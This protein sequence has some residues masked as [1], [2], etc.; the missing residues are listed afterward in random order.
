MTYITN[1]TPSF[2]AVVLSAID[3]T[4]SNPY[5]MVVKLFSVGDRFDFDILSKYFELASLWD[6]HK[7][8]SPFRIEKV[9]MYNTFIQ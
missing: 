3:Y 1:V 6:L 9:Q 7:G 2:D 4:Y 8:R 5:K